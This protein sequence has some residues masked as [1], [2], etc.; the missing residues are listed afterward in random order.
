M[1]KLNARK[2]SKEVVQAALHVKFVFEEEEPADGCQWRCK[3]F[4]D[5]TEEEQ[6][7]ATHAWRAAQA[8]EDEDAPAPGSAAEDA[9]APGSAAVDAPAP[10][11]WQCHCKSSC[12]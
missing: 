12:A 9:P 8:S 4:A 10:G 7:E 5:M 6:M 3:L 2:R 1:Q 11:T